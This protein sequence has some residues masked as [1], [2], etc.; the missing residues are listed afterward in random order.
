MSSGLKQDDERQMSK[1][2]ES[3]FNKPDLHDRILVF[4]VIA[5]CLSSLSE[6]SAEENGKCKNS[7]I[8]IDECIESNDESDCETAKNEAI[9]INIDEKETGIQ[10]CVFTLN[11][12]SYGNISFIYFN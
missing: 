3:E 5:S 2:Y 12:G 11:Y 7:E 10:D 1:L 4:D 6:T 8:Q 9:G